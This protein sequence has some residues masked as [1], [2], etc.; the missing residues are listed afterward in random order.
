M[1]QLVNEGE[2]ILSSPS[3]PLEEFG[4]LLHEGWKRKKTLSQKI[5][6]TNVA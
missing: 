1:L 6:N 3:C 5:T 2:S 4:R